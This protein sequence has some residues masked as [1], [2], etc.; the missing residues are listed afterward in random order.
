M[1]L[2]CNLVDDLQMQI[3]DES[4]GPNCCWVGSTKQIFLSTNVSPPL[5]IAVVVSMMGIILGRQLS[6]S[7][8]LKLKTFRLQLNLSV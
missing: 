1:Y 5:M 4:S 6:I 7:L 3:L 2:H 8:D